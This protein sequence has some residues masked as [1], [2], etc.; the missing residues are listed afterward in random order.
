M[1]DTPSSLAGLVATDTEFRVSLSPVQ[2]GLVFSVQSLGARRPEAEISRSFGTWDLW[3]N[4]WIPRPGQAGV[5]GK[6]TV[7]LSFLG[8]KLDSSPTPVLLFLE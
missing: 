4:H 8:R 6:G 7:F 2:R 3:R 1:D 5:L